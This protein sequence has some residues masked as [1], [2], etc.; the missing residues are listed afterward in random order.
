[1]ADFPFSTQFSLLYLTFRGYPSS[2]SNAYTIIMLYVCIFVHTCT[3]CTSNLQIIQETGKHMSD[4]TS[5]HQ[6]HT[7]SKIS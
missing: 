3:N 1:M 7:M 5:A 4:S 6:P 2:E